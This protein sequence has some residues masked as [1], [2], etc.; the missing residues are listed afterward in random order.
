MRKNFLILS[1]NIPL[2]GI[3]MNYYVIICPYKSQGRLNE[4][5]CPIRANS[6][7]SFFYAIRRCVP[8][9]FSLLL[10]SI[11]IYFKLILR[12]D[13][14]SHKNYIFSFT[15]LSY[16]YK[17]DIVFWGGKKNRAKIALF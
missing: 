6:L 9:G 11:I 1:Q 14:L 10:F 2:S 17:G 5:F 13:K 7:K 4:V 16:I 15:I 3:K 12:Y 8:L